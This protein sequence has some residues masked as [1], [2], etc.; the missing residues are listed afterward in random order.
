VETRQIEAEKLRFLEE[1]GA[2]AVPHSRRTLLEHLVGVR[3]LLEGWR[4]RPELLDAGLFHAVYGTE[5]FEGLRTPVERARLRELIG[6]EAERVVHLWSA[7]QRRSLAANA[8]REDAFQADA[9]DG[10]PLPLSP[11]ELADLVALWAADT[12]EQVDRLGG[13]TR[14]QPELY[15]LRG[16]APKPAR[17]ALERV[18]ADRP[19]AKSP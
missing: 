18:F 16:L 14:Y 2:G 9:R 17:A 4:V 8:G 7:I 15:A 6:E 3:A 11:Q 19:F 1:A 12:L 10:A 13:R 5:L